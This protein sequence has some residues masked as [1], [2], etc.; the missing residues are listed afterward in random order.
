ME[1][2][3]RTRWA[4]W[5]FSV[6]GPLV[7]SRL[8]HGDR[9]SHFREI[10]ARTHI[11]PDGGAVTLSPRTLEE[12]YYAFRRGGLDALATT[13]RSDR[14]TTHIRPELRERLVLLKREKPRRSARRLI[15]IL[16][17][18]GEAQ[19][20]E[21]SR[22]AVQRFLKGEGLSARGGEAEPPERRSFRHAEAADLWMGDVLHGPP[23]VSGGRVRKSYLIAFIDSATR[24][25]PA[26]E[27]RLSESAADHEYALKQA[28]LKHG[29]P[30]ALY[31]DNGP[32]QRSLSLQLIC[33]EL[34]VRLIHTE[35]F[36]PESKGAIERWNRTWREEVEDELPED[37]LPISELQSRVWS[38]L[39]V[40]YNA[41]IHGST[42]KAPLEHWLE[43]PTA[44]RP[45]PPHLDL[46]EVFLHRERRRVRRDGTVRFR[47]RFLEVRSS[48]VGTEVELR[49]DP[50]D[51]HA[52]PRI[53]R[54]GRFLCDTVP[55]DP[56]ANSLRKRHR[57]AEAPSKAVPPS[58]IDA[59]A[60]IQDEHTRRAR[61]PRDLRSDDDTH[62]DEREEYACV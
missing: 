25:V 60:L 62:D 1:S 8:E 35:A 3:D 6:L 20:G 5:R 53:F 36:S 52:L 44:L 56:V 30:R 47:G 19:K 9:R 2:D 16:E 13:P 38:W 11:D 18:R 49:F 45:T 34:S 7:S 46:D 15:K 28:L 29:L 42:G 50:F 58:G 40:E 23:V 43:D 26:A 59:L 37:P 4:L 57:P 55:L 21:L 54:D 48:L 22:S 51:E 17:R 24:F 33:A 10:A 32:A 39:A 27:V 31:L 41:R 14:G 12:W 61:P